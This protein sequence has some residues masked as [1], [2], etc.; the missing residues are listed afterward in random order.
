MARK[1]GSARQ[2]RT[3]AGAAGGSADHL[4]SLRRAAGPLDLRQGDRSGEPRRNRR[5]ASYWY[6]TERTGSA[7]LTLL[8]AEEERDDLPLV[9]LLRED[10]RAGA[11]PSTLVPPNVTRDLLRHWAVR[12]AHGGCS[13][14]SSKPS[15]RSSICSS[16]G[17]LGRLAFAGIQARAEEDLNRCWRASARHSAT[18]R[19]S[20]RA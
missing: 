13:S 11:R 9:N 10:V 14:A 5:P 12:T 7:Q 19:T 15:R 20:S 18:A 17:S 1:S 6:K 16:S 4:Q 3:V 2:G 8:L